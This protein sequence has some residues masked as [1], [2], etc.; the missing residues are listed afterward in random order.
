MIIAIGIALLAFIV[1]VVI[2]DIVRFFRI[3]VHSSVRCYLP[4]DEDNK[5]SR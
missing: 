2:V 1:I 4:D 3:P 5:A